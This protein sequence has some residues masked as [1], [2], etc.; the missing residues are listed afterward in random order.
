MV[1]TNDKKVLDMA[2]AHILNQMKGNGGVTAF[3]SQINYM[4]EP[5]RKA[6]AKMVEGGDFLIYNQDII[7]TLHRWGFTDDKRIMNYKGYAGGPLGLYTAVMVNAGSR[8]YEKYAKKH[9]M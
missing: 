3:V 5:I 1:G 2:E 9:K 4:R 8:L 6:I 7:R